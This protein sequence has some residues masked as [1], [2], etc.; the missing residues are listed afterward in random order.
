M[1]HLFVVAGC[2][3]FPATVKYSSMIK[4]HGLDTTDETMAQSTECLKWHLIFN[5]SNTAC[6]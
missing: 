4:Q 1:F 3:D 2:M 6:H 5:M